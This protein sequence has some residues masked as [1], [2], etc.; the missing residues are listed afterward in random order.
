MKKVF[1]IGAA[2]GNTA[3]LPRERSYTL[4]F[5]GITNGG[6]SVLTGGRQI[7]VNVNYDEIRHTLTVRIPKIAVTEEITVILEGK[8]ELAQN[9]VLKETF[10]YLEK[11]S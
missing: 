9:D 2:K 7:E 10:A 8:V 6:A 3:V 11:R 1:T 5:T 4:E